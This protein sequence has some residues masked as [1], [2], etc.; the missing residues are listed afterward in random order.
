ML[1]NPA[2]TYGIGQRLT[3]DAAERL[4]RNWSMVLFSGA[5]LIVSGVLILSIDWTVRSLATFVG[6]LFIFHGLMEAATL[7]VGDRAREAGILTGVLSALA[8]VA[9]VVWPAPGLVVLAIFLGTWLIVIGTIS[10]SGAF[11]ARHMVPS[12][13]LLL[14]SG[15]LEVALGVLA[16]ADPGA[17]LAALITVGG[18]WAVAAGVSRVVLS[19]ELKRLPQEAERAYASYMSGLAQRADNGATD[20]VSGARAAEA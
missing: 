5:L 1:F 14:I 7:G 18:I 3:R 16:L 20:P 8:G 9:I 12:W 10:M 2:A 4:A 6:A 15:I 13:W 19:F 11:A 17:T